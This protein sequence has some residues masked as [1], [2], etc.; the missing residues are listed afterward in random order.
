ME[1]CKA[2]L[3]DTMLLQHL[4]FPD[5]PHDLEFVAS[6]FTQKAAWKDEKRGEPLYWESRCARDADAT[7]QSGRVLVPM[8]GM[9]GLTELYE[10]VQ[11]PLA[12]ICRHVQDIGFRVDPGRIAIVRERLLKEMA[13]E[14]LLLP[15]E[16]RT[17][18]EPK[19]RRIPAPAGTVS[20]KTGK[21]LKF[22]LVDD[23]ETVTPWRSSAVVA[24][25][26]YNKLGLPTQL[27]AKSQQVTSDKTALE[28][29]YRRTRK[30][31]ILAILNLRKRDELI[32]TFCKETNATIGRMR[33]HLNVHGTSSGRLSSS[34]PN[35]Q[36]IPPAAR[37]I[38]VPSHDD[39][40]L[41]EADYSQIENRLVAHFAGDTERLARLGQKGFSEHKWLA[42]QFFNIPYEEVVKDNDKDAPYGKAKRIGHGTNYGMGP[43]KIAN[44]YDMEEREV[45]DLLFKWKQA[46][47]K[48]VAWQL[49]TARRAEQE[50]VLT[51]P[52]KRKRWFWTSNVYTESLSFL[53]QSTAAD[54]IFRA[55]IGL[56]YERVGWPVEKAMKAVRVIEPLPWPAQL[57]LQVHDSLI[58]ECP[59]AMVNQ[60]VRTVVR[61]MQQP[62]AELGGF[63]IPVEVKVGPSWA[64]CEP[65]ELL[66][67]ALAA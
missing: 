42:S 67:T 63:A 46:N 14:E 1:I 58:F 27:H 53:P 32:T 60:V 56:M 45:K 16:L 55:M 4:N 36:N 11:I 2:K 15:E 3:Y 40:V 61:V 51:T 7:L 52:F 37:V 57:L 33:P 23:M 59:R 41:V 13:D 24:D 22:L 9:H 19:R 39:F 48:T 54:I 10:Y 64:E 18:Q 30:R 44:L 62:W 66:E 43:R 50:G 28:K 26:L 29:L 47:P 35:L 6:Q 65:Y 12:L 25:Y 31:E 21:P 20:E 38:Y 17:R 49:E 34:D 8:T 5:M